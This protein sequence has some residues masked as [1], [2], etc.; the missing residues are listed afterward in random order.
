MDR[1]RQF[2]RP[3]FYG[4]L[5]AA[6]LVIAAQASYDTPIGASQMPAMSGDCTSSAGAVSLSC[7]KTNGTAFGT[8]ATANTGT[9]GANVPLLNGNNSYS[10]VST[11]SGALVLP[12]RVITAAGDVTVSASSDYFLCINKTTGAATTV[13]LPGSPAA[14]LTFVVKDCKG[15]AATN[16]ITITPASG[17]IDGAATFVQNVNHQAAVVSYDGTQWEVN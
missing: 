8:A 9:S 7:T 14:G 5:L 17:N 6:A 3:L 4:P 12:M 1:L 10:G 2:L 16:N 11:F 13:N 15:D